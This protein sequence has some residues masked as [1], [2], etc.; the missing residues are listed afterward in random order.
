MSTPPAPTRRRYAKRLPREE[1]RELILDAALRLLAR[2][3]WPALR[4]DPVAA[5]ADIA[6]SV[7]YSVFGSQQGLLE[8]LLAREHARAR[9]TAT[10]ALAAG[11]TAPDLATGLRAA[12]QTFLERVEQEPD[13]WRL[14]LIHPDGT[15]AHVRELSRSG[16]DQWWHEVEP[17]LAGMLADTGLEGLDP[18]LAAHIIRGNAEYLARLLLEQPARFS[19]ERLLRFVADV[20]A[21]LAAAD[22]RM[23][24]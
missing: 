1:R 23:P 13:T 2:E 24:R 21:R 15:P 8:A 14:I 19:S 5:E 20:T 3:G 17:V 18:A 12:L 4:V 7:V 16:R 10:A 22:S 6:K 11:Q 9:A